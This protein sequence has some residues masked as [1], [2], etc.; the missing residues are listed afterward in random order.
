MFRDPVNQIAS[1]I[2]EIT[3]DTLEPIQDKPPVW[4]EE[5]KSN[6][7]LKPLPVILPSDTK[8]KREEKRSGK[9]D[10]LD[11]NGEGSAK[12]DE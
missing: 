3:N 2:E 5:V 8:F 7:K 11:K 1:N 6:P 12:E 4:H 10:G 9:E